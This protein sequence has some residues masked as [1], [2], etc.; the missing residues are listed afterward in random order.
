M[1]LEQ[2]L[3]AITVLHDLPH[4]VAALGHEPYW[5][6]L[7]GR[8]LDRPGTGDPPGRAAIVGR[9]GEFRW[10]GLESGD[11][12][13]TARRVAA[14]LGSQGQTAGVLALCS[15]SRRLAVAV[16]FTDPVVLEVA[17]ESPSRLA[18]TALARIRGV[19][20][21]NPLAVA[22]RIREAIS[23]EELGQR[24]FLRFKAVLDRMTEGA[25]SPPGPDD[26]RTLALL[27]LTR[28]LFLYFVQCKGWLDGKPDTSTS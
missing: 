16:G 8:A 28:V 1:A 17:L 14:R 24:F 25:P 10:L 18:V 23:S 4:L 13:G 11:P 19:A 12:A 2:I 15:A 27:Q 20:E 21:R 22:A 7:E 26:R 3:R 9:C 6:E 5:E